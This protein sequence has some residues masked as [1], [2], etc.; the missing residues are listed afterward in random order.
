[1]L[2]SIRIP[3]C[4]GMLF[5]DKYAPCDKWEILT[6]KNNSLFLWNSNFA[7]CAVFLI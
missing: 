3:D 5:E 6:L 2:S 7:G 1:M 4:Q